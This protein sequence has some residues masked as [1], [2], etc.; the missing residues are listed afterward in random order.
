MIVIVTKI[1][2]SDGNKNSDSNGNRDSDS[3][4]W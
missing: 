2:D 3:D 4:K 1:S